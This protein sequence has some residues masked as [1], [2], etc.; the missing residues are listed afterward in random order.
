MKIN[1][2]PT[3]RQIL[4][5]IMIGVLS[6]GC[7]SPKAE[8]AKIPVAQKGVLDL[9][10]WNFDRNGSINLNGEWEFY[11][12]QLRTP[13]DFNETATDIIA[14]RLTGTIR[15][16]GSWWGYPLKN[17]KL[18]PI[19]Y[20]TYRLEVLLPDKDR[21]MGLNLPQ[22]YT[23]YKL[24]VNGRLVSSGGKVGKTLLTT[25]PQY[26]QRVVSCE[27][28][29][30][31]LELVIQVANFH[32]HRCGIM[33]PI[34]LG[35]DNRISQTN[36][37]QWTFGLLV[38][39]SFLLMGLYNLSLYFTLKQGSAPLFMAIFFGIG[40][41]RLT[42]VGPNF[43]TQVF[44]DFSWEL[45]MKIEYF[46]FYFCG[47]VFYRMIRRLYPGEFP[48]S[49]IT[50][51]TWAGSIFALITILTPA[52]VY[53]Y[54]AP[55]FQL[56]L[57]GSVIYM[58]VVLGMVSVKRREY[59]MISIFV[60]IFLS[61]FNDILFYYNLVYAEFPIIPII[62]G[63]NKLP[64]WPWTIPIGF[65]SMVFFIFVFNL[66]TLKITQHYFTKSGYA[67]KAELAAAVMEEHDLTPREMELVRYIIQGYSNKEIAALFSISEGTVKTHLHRIFQ[68]TGARNR[69]ELS[70][71]LKK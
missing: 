6:G 15:L 68:K 12:E 8:S 27:P 5:L 66:L 30:G 24:W 37:L 28:I 33:R 44:P 3:L 16:P 50:F 45:A 56:I 22:I 71:L 49:L 25:T 34:Q 60:I 43:Y 61:L 29:K 58:G 70:H 41:I 46:T 32:H 13:M 31:R 53:T 7:S 39:G 36:T 20:A 65:L 40:V 51:I 67:A 55:I 62:D 59:L 1:R 4:I 14:P 63:F 35:L 9:R 10:S 48:S 54:L 2:I 64:F 69:T 23:A 21:L 42:L 38:M 19:G 47:P 11:W 57:L 18:T 52:R 17:K 26:I